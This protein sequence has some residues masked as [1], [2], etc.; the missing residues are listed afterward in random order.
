MQKHWKNV[1]ILYITLF[2]K[3]FLSVKNASYIVTPI[4]FKRSQLYHIHCM[5]TILSS[6]RIDMHEKQEAD[7]DF[8]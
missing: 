1:I 8:F 7:G 6:E 5:Y 4:L 3:Y 2:P